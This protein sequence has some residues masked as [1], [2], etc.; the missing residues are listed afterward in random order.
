MSKITTAI[1]VIN[2]PSPKSMSIPVL[3]IDDNRKY[4]ALLRERL[5]KTG[6]TVEHILSSRQAYEHFS[7]ASP[8]SYQIIIT[9]ITME[10][11]VS[12]ILLTRRIRN[13]GFKGCMVIY[14]TGFNFKIV[15][16]LSVLFFKLFR[17][18]GL[19]PKDGLIAGKPE[20]TRISRNPLLGT[21]ASALR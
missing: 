8:N 15:L 11:Q 21:I 2:Q 10:T 19:I 13:M 16:W 9:D 12:G 18:D 20:L 5:E 14:S 6:C 1:D 17:A 3:I 4:T 7:G